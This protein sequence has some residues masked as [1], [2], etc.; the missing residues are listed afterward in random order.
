MLR[1]AIPIDLGVKL[2]PEAAL[3]RFAACFADLDDPRTGNV[4]L[5]DFPKY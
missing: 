3:D 2:A 4:A 1:D 5:H